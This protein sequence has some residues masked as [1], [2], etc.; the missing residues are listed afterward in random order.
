MANTWLPYLIAIVMCALALTIYEIFAKQI[1]CKKFDF[2]NDSQGQGIEK[3]DLCQLTGNVW[4]YIVDFFRIF[5]TRPNAFTQKDLQTQRETGVMTK[6]SICKANFMANV[7]TA[8]KYEVAYGLSIS[9]FRF[10]IGP[11]ETLKSYTFPLRISLK[12]WQICIVRWSDHQL[13]YD[14]I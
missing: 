14:E 13:I 5:A 12:W 3:R 1:K 10:D 4:F 6:G 11:L 8:I 7:V 9:I 2:G